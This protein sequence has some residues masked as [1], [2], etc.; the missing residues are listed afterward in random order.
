MVWPRIARI[1]LSKNSIISITGITW[2]AMTALMLQ[3]EAFSSEDGSRWN[4]KCASFDISYKNGPCSKNSSLADILNRTTSTRDIRP[5]ISVSAALLKHVCGVN[6]PFRPYIWAPV[7]TVQGATVEL[8]ELLAYVESGEAFGSDRLYQAAEFGGDATTSERHLGLCKAG[9]AEQAPTDCV[10]VAII[11]TNG[12][13]VR[14]APIRRSG[15]CPRASLGIPPYS[16]TF[17]IEAEALGPSE[18]LGKVREN[19]ES[20]FNPP[21]RE[22]QFEIPDYKPIMYNVN[23][24]KETVRE[25]ISGIL[26]NSKIETVILDVSL[27]GG[28]LS[29]IP[30]KYG[31]AVTVSYSPY[32]WWENT[33]NLKIED[34]SLTQIELDKYEEAFRCAVDAAIR[35]T[36]SEHKWISAP[37][38][39]TL[40]LQCIIQATENQVRGW[41]TKDP[42][43]RTYGKR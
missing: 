33:G 20:S 11:A 13:W 8:A 32:V 36:C 38:G 22:G 18:F 14:A 39:N 37:D 5:G 24:F 6:T 16:F 35:D 31:T 1:S 21:N 23:S 28:E 2:T 7:E 26:H 29:K 43:F 41:L 15:S 40:S 3:N 34:S 27:T 19:I 12:T 30:A 4:I 17:E 25:K 9:K 42:C 10:T